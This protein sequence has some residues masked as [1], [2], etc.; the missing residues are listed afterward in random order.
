MSFDMPRGHFIH[1]NL[2]FPFFIEYRRQQ[3]CSPFCVSLWHISAGTETNKWVH[4]RPPLKRSWRRS[5]KLILTNSSCFS[6]WKVL[7]FEKRFLKLRFKESWIECVENLNS[8]VC[9][10][11]LYHW[12]STPYDYFHVW[13]NAK[14]SIANFYCFDKSFKLEPFLWVSSSS[15][16]GFLLYIFLLFPIT[17]YFLLK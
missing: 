14:K 8:F 10:S 7:S 1:Q 17:V 2:F 11:H 5:A 6:P 3:F 15:A 4:M 12:V 9:R 13:S 16:S